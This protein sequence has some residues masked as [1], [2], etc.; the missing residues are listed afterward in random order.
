MKL[1]KQT[2]SK[3]SFKLVVSEMYGDVCA[4]DCLVNGQKVLVVTVYISP[5]IP[6]DK[7]KILIF[8]TL[9][10]YSPKV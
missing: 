3:T 4:A 6:S 9:A 8:S 2:I 7:W 1:D 5:N 10:G